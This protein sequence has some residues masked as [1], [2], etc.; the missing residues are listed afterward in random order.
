M[1]SREETLTG[2]CRSSERV[3]APARPDCILAIGSQRL[4]AILAEERHDSLLL[5]IHGN[6]LFWVDDEGELQTPDLAVTVRVS[7]IVCVEKAGDDSG[8]QVPEFRIAVARLGQ[9]AVKRPQPSRISVQEA[10]CSRPAARFR[11]PAVL[12]TGGLAALALVLTPIV[13]VAVVWLNH[14]HKVHSIE[15]HNTD[16][17]IF[18]TPLPTPAIKQQAAEDVASRSFREIRQLPGVEPFL[19]AV[20]AEK[21]ALTPSQAGALKRLDKTTQQALEDLEKYWE[22]SGR[23][24]LARRQ[25]EVLEAARHEALQLLTDE[26]RQR[27]EALTR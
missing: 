19:Q 27:W 25:N 16:T 4:P 23:L 1:E 12:T 2:S 26:Q 22:S 17:A 8:S 10:Y 18:D 7:S 24:E 5:L 15:S 20:V 21:L 14:L 11:K 9:T 13:V 6:P 3:A